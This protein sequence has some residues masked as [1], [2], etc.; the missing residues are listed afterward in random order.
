MK[1]RRRKE[2]QK[3]FFSIE[4][5]VFGIIWEGWFLSL[6]NWVDFKI[7]QFSLL[8]SYHIIMQHL[9]TSYGTHTSVFHSL[10]D[11]KI[12]TSVFFSIRK[13]NGYCIYTK[14][15]CNYFL[16]NCVNQGVKKKKQRNSTTKFWF[17]KLWD[18]FESTVAMV[19]RVW[20]QHFKVT[21]RSRYYHSVQVSR[22]NQ[23]VISH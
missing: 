17:L 10:P 23:S 12:I 15:G 18:S 19:S 21:Q 1:M 7:V 4:F 14:S 8:F 2:I 22:N 6:D 20:N 11:G 9:D 5:Y 16:M 13:V 3:I